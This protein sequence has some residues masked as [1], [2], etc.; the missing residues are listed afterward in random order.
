MK[1]P[2]AHRLL[3]PKI[4]EKI[5]RDLAPINLECCSLEAR[6]YFQKFLEHL[7]L[8]I[9][10]LDHLLQEWM[11]LAVLGVCQGFSERNLDPELPEHQEVFFLVIEDVKGVFHKISPKAPEDEISSLKRQV[12]DFGTQWVYYLDWKLYMSTELY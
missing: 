9:E 7:E 8:E 2:D 1:K 10:G 5:P 4:G 3:D 6:N 12:F 11:G